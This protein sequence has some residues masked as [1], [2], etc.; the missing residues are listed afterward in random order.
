M[1]SVNLT[2]GVITTEHPPESL[3]RKY[4]GGYGIGARMLWD[5]VPVGADPMGPENMLGFVR[6]WRSDA[7]SFVSPARNVRSVHRFFPLSADA[8]YW[9]AHPRRR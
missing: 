3:Y 6:D 5:R 7:L 2:T 4:L 8:T 1:M 9:W